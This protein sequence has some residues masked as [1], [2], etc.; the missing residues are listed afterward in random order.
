MGIM[1]AVDDI[2]LAVEVL[3]KKNKSPDIRNLSHPQHDALQLVAGY[4]YLQG[5][6]SSCGR[7]ALLL[8]LAHRP[9]L[10]MLLAVS[11][12]H[13]ARSHPVLM[14]FDDHT[15]HQL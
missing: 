2:D 4:F 9:A 6:S 13:S 1:T 7:T 12:R 15:L 5:C 10:A 14:R 11:D 8:V 3:Q